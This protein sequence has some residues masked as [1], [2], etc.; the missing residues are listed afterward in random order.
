MMKLKSIYV[1]WM[2][3]F[4]K[5]N[6]E[7][8]GRRA[9]EKAKGE[10]S[11]DNPGGVDEDEGYPIYNYAYPL[12]RD[13]I[14]DDIVLKVCEETNCTVVYNHQEGRYYLALTGC[15][16][17][18]SQSIAMAYLIVDECIEWDMLED[19]YIGSPF[20]VDRDQYRRI[21]EALDRQLSIAMG[22]F[23]MRHQEVRKALKCLTKNETKPR[24]VS[25]SGV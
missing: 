13:E 6:W 14:E 21:L 16:M 18:M 7:I 15:G 9:L 5:E 3:E 22:N 17:D 24:E 1:D 4:S 11:E 23:G 2:N 20:S 19:I 25:K 12:F 8:V 10:W